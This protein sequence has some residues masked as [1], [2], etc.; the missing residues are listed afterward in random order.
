MICSWIRVSYIIPCMLLEVS[1]GLTATKYSSTQ[2]QYSARSRSL[3][4]HVRR[5][6]PMRS[7]SLIISCTD[8]GSQV[9][10]QV[11]PMVK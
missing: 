11:L 3:S 5:A 2:W 6:S 1:D 9:L 7:S 10:L 8:G 4:V